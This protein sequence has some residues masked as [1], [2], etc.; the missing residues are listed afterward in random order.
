MKRTKFLI[1]NIFI[2][3]FLVIYIGSIFKFVVSVISSVTY[4]VS[5]SSIFVLEFELK[6]NTG[7]NSDY[8]RDFCYDEIRNQTKRQY[9]EYGEVTNYNQSVINDESLRHLS[10]W[11]IEAITIDNQKKVYVLQEKTYYNSTNNFKMD[12]SIIDLSFYFFT[13]LPMKLARFT[14][15][16]Y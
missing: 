2:P 5:K 14:N 11:D 6:Y 9:N 16:S 8:W 10:K 4:P 15:F 7:I 13:F 1:N 12:I 3:I